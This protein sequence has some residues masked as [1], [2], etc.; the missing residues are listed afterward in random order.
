MKGLILKDLYM[1][2]KYCKAI[3]IF[4]VF[5]SIIAIFDNSTIYW[6]LLP[7]ILSGNIP[8]SVLAYDEQSRWNSYSDTL[9]CSRTQ[10]V[11][12]KYILTLF[13]VGGI[14]VLLSV[15]LAISELIISNFIFTD[16]I[17]AITGVLVLGMIPP[18]LILP[19]IFK[20]GTEKGRIMYTVVIAVLIGGISILACFLNDTA[21]A[22]Y[23][24]GVY[25]SET[26]I[27]AIIVIVTF[28]GSWT[29]SANIYKKREL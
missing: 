11:S 20:Y 24:A 21:Q 25:F 22:P 23:T 17:V 26:L 1:S 15:V 16:Y 19:I 28:I 27:T 4:I 5:F 6:I 7:V 2:F 14:W 13:S 8:V 3:Y 10:A 9:P 29:L 12:S 18:A